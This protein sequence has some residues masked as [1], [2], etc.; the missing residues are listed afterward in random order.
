MANFDSAVSSVVQ[1][2]HDNGNVST[3]MEVNSSKSLSREELYDQ[4]LG[5]AL[6]LNATTE[7]ESKWPEWYRELPD[8]TLGE[9]QRERERIEKRDRFFALAHAV[10]S[11]P[12]RNG[13]S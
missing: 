7:I 6:E 8:A 12:S 4:T 1:S 10:A 9:L 13:A 2:Q 11:E 3:D 5:L